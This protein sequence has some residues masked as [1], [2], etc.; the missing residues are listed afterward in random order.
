MD[1]TTIV[2]ISVASVLIVL[3]IPLVIYLTYPIDQQEPVEQIV[4]DAFQ[5]LSIPRP[6]PR[7]VHG[8]Y[9]YTALRGSRNIIRGFFMWR[10]SRVGV[11]VVDGDL[12]S[13]VFMSRYRS[14]AEEKCID[15]EELARYMNGTKVVAIGY[16]FRTPRGLTFIPIEVHMNGMRFVYTPR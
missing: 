1:R 14:L 9:G 10:D 7:F 13:T 4:E 12:V 15:G 8:V 3:S 16:L 11:F 2:M 6:P 5:Y